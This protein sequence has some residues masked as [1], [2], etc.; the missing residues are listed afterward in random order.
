MKLGFFV[1]QAGN[2]SSTRLINIAVCAAAIAI[3]GWLTYEGK[4]TE[5]YFLALLA[6]G[7]GVQSYGKFVESREAKKDS[8]N[9]Q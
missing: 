2:Y 9:T 3:C 8:A 1:D 5:G 4:M 6:Y 7:G